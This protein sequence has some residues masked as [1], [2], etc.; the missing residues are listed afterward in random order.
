MKKLSGGKIL[1]AVIIAAIALTGCVKQGASV[2][3]DNQAPQMVPIAQAQ[4]AAPK[5]KP[6]VHMPPPPPE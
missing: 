3:E 4:P 1:S 2:K 6:M 5:V